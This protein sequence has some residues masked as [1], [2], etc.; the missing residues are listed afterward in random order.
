MTAFPELKKA[1]HQWVKE[2]LP[3]LAADPNARFSWSDQPRWGSDQG[4]FREVE[5]PVQGWGL[6]HL[7]QFQHLASWSKIDEIFR[8][9]HRLN[10]QIDTLVGTAQGGHRLEAFNLAVHA[11]PNPDELDHPDESFERN[12]AQLEG[13]LAADELEFKVIWPVPGLTA[14]NLPLQLESAIELDAMTDQELVVA[15]QT[16]IIRPSVPR[17]IVFQPTIADRTC[18]RYRYRLRKLVGDYGEEAGPEMQKLVRRFDDIRSVI[19][20]SLALILPEPM[21]TAGSFMVSGGEWNPTGE[22]MSYNHVSI[23]TAARR[24]RIEL[25]SSLESN[26]QQIWGHLSRRDLVQRHKGLALALRRLSYQAQRERPEDELLDT[27]IAAEAL[28]LTEL[29]NE[30]YRGELRYRLALRA[31]VWAD[32]SEL[33]LAKSEILKLMQ[34]AYDARSAIAHGGTPSTKIMKI[35]GRP[36]EL[37]ELVKK[38]KDVIS[39][40]CHKALTAAASGQGWPPDWETIVLT[41][42]NR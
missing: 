13:F 7:G 42:Q 19:E 15:L 2:I 27:M 9:D 33:G 30:P 31:A 28:Y 29:G 16:E 32:A 10:R 8:S 23:P 21:M 26:L 5:R 37:P 12:Y 39:A 3:K 36:V 41:G 24:R 34:S 18:F 38:T 14:D 6:H 17:M 25:C 1:M 40:G 35:Q 4:V 20:E 11:I 22:W